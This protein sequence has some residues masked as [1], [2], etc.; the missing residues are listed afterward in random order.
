MGGF[1]SAHFRKYVDLTTR[2]FRAV[3][4]HTEDIAKLM[5]IMSH[6]SCYPAFRYN[7]RAI[8]D[9]RNRMMLDISDENLD[10]AVMNLMT[11]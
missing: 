2:A 5:E 7:P 3:R 1:D 11:A 6:M 4:Q 10:G 8:E 9:M